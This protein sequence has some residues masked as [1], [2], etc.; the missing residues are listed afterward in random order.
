MAEQDTKAIVGV[1]RKDPTRRRGRN[2]QGTGI[3]IHL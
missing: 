2:N 1:D 3:G